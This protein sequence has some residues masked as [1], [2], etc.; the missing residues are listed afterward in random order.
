VVR[1]AVMVIWVPGADC[2][3][4]PLYGALEGS[5][6]TVVG[7]I[8]LQGRV[9]VWSRALSAHREFPIIGLG[10]GTFRGSIADSVRFLSPR[11]SSGHIAPCHSVFLQVSV[12][13]SWPRLMGYLGRQAAAAVRWE[14]MRW[15][16]W[17][18]WVALGAMS[19]LL[20][21][22]V[23]ELADTMARGHKPSFLDR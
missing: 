14:K 5:M 13:V 4:Q 15:G 23:S 9:G 2:A 20:R 12:D 19:A 16:G 21:Y 7:E 6:E 11:L 18:R 1:K 8:P 17:E 22:H 3:A 10:A